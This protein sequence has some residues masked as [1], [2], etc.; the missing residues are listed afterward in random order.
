MYHQMY[1]YNQARG[2]KSKVF[3]AASHIAM[4]EVDAVLR[5]ITLP[6]IIRQAIFFRYTVPGMERDAMAS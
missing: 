1:Q 3:A 5:P 4:C 2:I 6:N